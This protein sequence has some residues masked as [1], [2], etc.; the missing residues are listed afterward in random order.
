MA[1]GTALLSL[2]ELVA[3]GENFG[4]SV[5][6]PC[7][8]ALDGDLGA[9]KTTLVQAIARGYGVTASVTSPTFALVHE[10][11]GGGA[12]VYHLDLYRLHDARELL[13][14]GW[15]EIVEREALV[16]IEW[17]DRAG[18]ALPATAIHLALA[19]VPNDHEHRLLTRR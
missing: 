8:V 17:P 18:G 16:L 13:Y 15:N 3:W 19:H 12:T 9:G 4:R 14:I 10:Y 5:R 6:A 11:G 7:I 1:T 2:A